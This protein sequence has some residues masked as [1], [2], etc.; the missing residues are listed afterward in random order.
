MI[1]NVNPT[2]PLRWAFFAHAYNLGDLSRAIE[3]ALAMQATGATVGFFHRG[4]TYVEQIAAAG[5]KAIGLLPMVSEEQ[6]AILMAL[7]QHRAPLG[8]PL[9]YCA[10]ELVAMVESE[11]A[12]FRDF[13]PDGVYCGLNLSC[14]ISVPHAKLPMVTLV[15]TALCPAFFRAGLAEFPDAM[16][17]VLLRHLVPRWLKRKL[18]NRIM[19]GDV[20][21]RSAAVFNQVRKRYGLSPLFN[22]TSLVRGDLTLLPDLPELSGLAADALPPGYAYS[23][24]LFARMA[25]P[26]T[27]AVRRVFSRPGLKLYCAM[28]S[29]VPSELLRRV[30][31]ILRVRDDWNVVCATAH[32]LDPQELGPEGANFHATR[33]LP[34]RE[35][36]ALADVAVTHGGQG[37]V[38]TAIACGTPIVG[39]AMQWEQQ[40]NLDA[41]ANAGAA[42]RIPTYRV[43]ARTVVAAIETAASPEYRKRMATFQRRVQPC[44]GAERAAQLMNA[45]VQRLPLNE[46]DVLTAADQR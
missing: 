39:V 45:F 17:S 9:P 13:Q 15:P 1:L 3:V 8:T 37:T 33:F 4:G 12:A 27:D 42:V 6:N 22:L 23:E 20:A 26:V 24:P 46:L 16:D 29:S 35:V 5:L 10:E 36:N 21:K 14:M 30:V 38:Q 18:I 32:T 2:R 19:L 31:Q 41:L 40:A 25:L 44:N 11:L 34:A 7:D 28:G 43:D